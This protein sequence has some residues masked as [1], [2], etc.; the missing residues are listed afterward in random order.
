M[1]E[2]ENI[3][4]TQQIFKA[5]GEGNL[6]F[7][8]NLLAED[9][10]WYVAGS[11]EYTPLAGKYHGVEQVAQIFKT[12]G[13]FL[14]LKQ[15]QPQEFVAQGDRVVVFGHAIGCVHPTN[16]AVEYDWVHFYT[17]RNGKITKFS[18]YLDTA[19]IAAAFDNLKSVF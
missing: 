16:R 12:V 14:E 6:Q 17:L 10:E 2:Q 9:V 18:E 1:N 3:Q 13:E 7:L 11:P 15:F 5:F 8:L 19:A 4:L